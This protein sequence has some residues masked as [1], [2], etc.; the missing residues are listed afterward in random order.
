MSIEER[1][2]T[3]ASSVLHPVDVPISSGPPT[4]Y[5]QCRKLGGTFDRIFGFPGHIFANFS[6]SIIAHDGRKI[7]AW[8]AQLR[9]FVF[10]ESGNYQYLQQMPTEIWISEIRNNQLIRPKRLFHK[11]HKLSHEDPR[12][13]IGSDGEL[14]CQFVVSTY[15]TT[16]RSKYSRKFN[17]SKVAVAH[18]DDYLCGGNV[19]IPPIGNNSNAEAWEKNWCFFADGQELKLLYSVLPLV[20]HSDSGAKTQIDST[21]LQTLVTGTSATF[22]SLPPVKYGDHY[23]VFYHWKQMAMD[24]SG[25]GSPDL[26][27]WLNAFMMD[28]DLSMITQIRKKPIFIG[29]KNDVRI[30]WTDAFGTVKSRQPCCCL[31][32]GLIIEEDELIMSIG[33]ND[34]F[35]GLAR[36]PIE[37]I[38]SGMQDM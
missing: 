13:F 24:E 26:I 29:S 8:R 3:E 30:N 19:T 35:C 6:P 21:C 33:I 15:A 36:L 14:Y 9:P 34:A 25:S 37:S 22:N 31:P 2:F 7:I 17:K 32:F 38:L 4:I 23:I 5:Q 27:Y 11:P 20:I 18:V 12:L 16:L 10:N 28:K 1:Y